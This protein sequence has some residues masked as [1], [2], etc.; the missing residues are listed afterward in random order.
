[1]H[2]LFV[3]LIVGGF[4]FHFLSTFPVSPYSSRIAWGC[5]LAASIMWALGAMS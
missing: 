5:W 3:L 1:M 2:L 4:L